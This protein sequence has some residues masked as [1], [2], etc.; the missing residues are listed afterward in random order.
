MTSILRRLRSEPAEQRGAWPTATFQ[1]YADYLKF[2]G[3]QYLLGTM[4]GSKP[5]MPDPH[6]V[7]Y[8]RSI[9]QRNGVVAAAVTARALLLSQVRFIWR[10]TR[11]SDTPGRTFGARN[12]APLERP[13][14]TT[15]PE[16]LY[17]LELDV[18][19][20]GNAYVARREN[21]IMRLRPDWVTIIL[22]SDSDPEYDG[23][24]MLPP[25][26]AREIGIVYQPKSGAK[27]GRPE[28][29]LPGE[30]AHWMPEPDPIEFWRGSSWVTSVLR[31]V[32]TDGQVTDHQSKFFENAATPNL[33]FL[34]DPSKN[35]E[36]VKQFA[37]ALNERHAGPGNA[38]KN[39]FLGGGTDVK[40]VGSD[41]AALN[42]KDVSGGFESR[43]AA[44]SRVPAVVL[45][46]REGLAGSSLNSGNYAQTRRL[47]A[48][49]W[50]SPTVQGLCAALEAIVTPDADSELWYDP[51]EVL[52]LQEDQKDA[53]EILQM[54]MAALR[55]GIDGGWEPDAL[56][57]AITTNDPRKLIG[58]HTGLTSVQLTPPATGEPDPKETP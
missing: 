51:S 1:Q 57:E 42:L 35:P 34:M 53:A 26:D 10:N 29:F 4:Q 8:V 39:M 16:L 21:R 23:N 47:W 40:V 7:G 5:D 6:F 37:A 58:R 54:Q 41:L 48:D 24:D 49:G 17:R 9:H 38:F 18:S 12:L 56:V 3:Q 22:G 32:S 19:Y 46:T 45:G 15:R 33:V 36:Q 52:F 55:Q 27:V 43:I 11:A 20:A 13:G 50:F 14:E 25:A 31:E 28:V 44:R 30:Y 2:Q